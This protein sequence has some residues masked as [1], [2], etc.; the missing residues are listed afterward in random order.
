MT[1]CLGK[2][3]RKIIRVGKSVAV[4]LPREYLE[5]HNLKLGDKIELNFNEVLQISPV[6]EGEIKKKLGKAGA[7]A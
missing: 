3:I 4:T 5:A 2:D 1:E 7:R 6:D